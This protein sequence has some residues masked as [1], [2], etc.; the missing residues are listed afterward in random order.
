[1]P[2]QQR[3]NSRSLPTSPSTT[4]A[5]RRTL[6]TRSMRTTLD[7]VDP[8]LGGFLATRPEYAAYAAENMGKH[9][10]PTLRNVNLGSDQ[11]AKAYGHNGYFK[12]LY[13]IVH[14]YNTRDVLPTCPGAYTEAQA[15]AAN[16]WPAAEVAAN[17]NTGGTGQPGVDQGRR[18]GDRCLPEDAR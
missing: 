6:K 5:C 10:V 7:F 18:G 9:K 2:Y 1:M 15:L 4:W 16:C 3:G 12:S 14:F 13:G 11:F 17:I 8:G